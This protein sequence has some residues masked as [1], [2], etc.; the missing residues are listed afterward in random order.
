MFI[1]INSVDIVCGFIDSDF[2]EN[3][4]LLDAYLILKQ[5]KA[6]KKIKIKKGFHNIFSEKLALN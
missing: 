1:F 2:K 3:Y 4:Y 5:T 6:I